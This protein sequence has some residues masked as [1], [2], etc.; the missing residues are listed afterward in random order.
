MSPAF[1]SDMSEI[2]I[3]SKK[4]KKVF[5]CHA[6]FHFPVLLIRYFGKFY[7]VIF[8]GWNICIS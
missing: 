6:I 5:M 4:K 3:E 8:V 2:F 1:L 7:F